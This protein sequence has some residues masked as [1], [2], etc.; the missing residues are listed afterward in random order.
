MVS[1]RQRCRR[2][3][4]AHKLPSHISKIVL[5]TV[6]IGPPKGTR[7]G[8]QY[9]TLWGVVS[10]EL[11]YPLVS[12]YRAKE[13]SSLCSSV[14][15]LTCSEGDPTPTILRTVGNLYKECPAKSSRLSLSQKSGAL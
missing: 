4:E 5:S 10:V 6:K 14:N 8:Q 15:V 12:N 1:C 7:T 2:P 11:T 3:S 13:Q 9:A